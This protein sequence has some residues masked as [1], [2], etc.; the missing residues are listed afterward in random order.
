MI[1]DRIENKQVSRV[2]KLEIINKQRVDETKSRK[3]KDNI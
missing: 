3:F 2:S 1:N